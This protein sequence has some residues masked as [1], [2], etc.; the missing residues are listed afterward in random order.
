MEKQEVAV[1]KPSDAIATLAKKI[2]SIKL[3]TETQYKTN[4]KIQTTSGSLDIK[5]VTNEEELVKAYSSVSAR[6]N[7][8]DKAYE[9]LG[10]T[11][12]P[13]AK[14]DGGTLEEWKHDIQLRLEIIRQK[15]TLDNLEGLKK[16]WE[17]LMDKE[18]RKELLLKKM[19][20]VL[21]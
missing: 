11:S 1:V 13:A 10:Y 3:I 15:N 5:T 9:E 19:N 21:K 6:I 8:L 18:D 2:E 16:E 12:Y 4:G 7:A 14:I 20:E 17:G